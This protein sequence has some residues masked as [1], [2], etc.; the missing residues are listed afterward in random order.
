MASLTL[1]ASGV[2][3]G[4]IRPL[5]ILHDL[6]QVADLIELCFASNLDEDG[7]S[8]LDQMR[9]AGRDTAFLTWAGRI[10]DSASMPLTGF[11][12][13]EDGKII[14]NASLILQTH[15]SRKIAM[16][17]NIA[18]H[19]DHRR[20][21]IGRALTARAMTAAQQR[22]A[23]EFWLHVRHDNPTAI[24][25]YRDLEFTE[26]ARRTTYQT[27]VG[28]PF[29]GLSAPTNLLQGAS[30]N[31]TTGDIAIARPHP[32]HWPIQR[33]WLQRAH[34]E[35]LSWYAHWDWKAVGPGFK[36]WLRRAVV[37][38]DVR[39]WAAVR[40]SQLLATV[41]WMPTLR[42]SN[43]LWIAAPPDGEP[44]GLGLALETARRYL[45]HYRRLVV[46]YPAGEMVSAVE[47]AGFEAYRTLI[48]MRA[49]ATSGAI[50][51]STP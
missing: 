10:M 9:R 47:S 8:Y 20:R 12:W 28:A 19:P 25:I 49:D 38:A 17:A 36:N 40:G 43:A 21:G 4:A 11:V 22:G 50:V 2:R 18:T 7:Q 39:Q 51:R 42:A 44:A 13:E 14:G 34:P 29:S 35:E 31:R 3:T 26:R 16:L 15:R 6:S 48:W 46:E 32:L 24:K 37:E 5:N 1:S 30:P 27:K 45:A 23:R 33:E 41:S